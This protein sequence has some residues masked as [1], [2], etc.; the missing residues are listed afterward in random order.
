MPDS[1]ALYPNGPSNT[2][3]NDPV[4]DENFRAAST[5]MQLSPQEQFLYK[6][7]LTNLTSSGGVD[8]PD[9]SRS[10]LYV[11]TFG[12]GDKTYVIPSVWNGKILAPDDSLAKAKSKGLD[13]F[14]SYASEDE[15]KQRYNTMHSYME[16]DTAKYLDTRNS[17]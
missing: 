17:P 12:I 2:L 9:G 14:P 4:G 3:G 16:K 6:M 11:N 8:N 15:A 7:H 5:D 13:N 10:T 1:Q